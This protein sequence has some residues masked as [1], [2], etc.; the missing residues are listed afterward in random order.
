[1]RTPKKSVIKD[2]LK[3]AKKKII[4]E[5]LPITEWDFCTGLHLGG[6][7]D[8]CNNNWQKKRLGDTWTGYYDDSF[9]FR[10]KITVPEQFAN[11]RVFLNVDFGGELVLRINGELVGSF[12]STM[13][14][15]WVHRDVFPL[16]NLE[17]GQELNLELYGGINTAG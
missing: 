13:N 1:M 7:K 3:Q 15:G 10:S 8:E 9:W 4:R 2:L 16:Q 14:D 12:S 17:A 6:G 11:S 5:N